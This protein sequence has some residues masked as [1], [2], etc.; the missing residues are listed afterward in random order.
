MFNN[1]ESNKDYK[2]IGEITKELGL[3]NK[4]TGSLQTHTIRFWETQFKQIK[5][6][7]RAGNRRY[8]SKKNIQKIKQIKYLLKDRG[9]TIKGAKKLLE[10]KNLNLLDDN[11]D[12]KVYNSNKDKEN[13]IKKRIK[14][15]VNI[16][17]ELKEFK[18]G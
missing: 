6:K 13:S 12:L 7:I 15:I 9:L 17:K 4:K 8:Y 2:T 5:P 16:L 11:D 10:S 18:N 14:K 1:D 3:I